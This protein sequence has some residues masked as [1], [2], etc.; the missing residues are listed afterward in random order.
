MLPDE[1]ARI[2]LPWIS[3]DTRPVSGS[4]IDL[5]QFPVVGRNPV[6]E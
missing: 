6:K 4:I 5:E 3:G 1:I 2:A